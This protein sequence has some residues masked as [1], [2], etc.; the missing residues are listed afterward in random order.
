M[1]DLGLQPWA[2]DFLTKEQ[3]GKEHLYPLHLVYCSSCG[4]VQLDF[5]VPKEVMFSDH[6]YVSGTTKTL[7]NHF[8]ETARYVRNTFFPHATS[9]SV[10]DIGSNDGTQLV[11]YK[12]LGF[13]T[14]GV[15]SCGRVA[16]MAE[17]RGIH[18][19]VD[20]FNEECARK[21]PKKF[22]V[23]NAAGVF[24]HLEELHSATRGIKHVL[25]E[26][27][28]FVIQFLYMKSIVENL[29]FD[30]IYHEHLLYYTLRTVE[31]LLALHGLSPFDGYLAPIHGGSMILFVS[32]AG[33][34]PVS[35]R[36][37]ALYAEEDKAGANSLSWYQKFAQQVQRMKTDTLAYLSAKKKEGKRI[38]GM[39][40]PVK[41]NTFLNFCGIGAQYLDCLVEKNPL[42][43]GLYSPGTHLPIVLEEELTN[44][45]DVYLVL[46]WN[47][48]GEI[49][50]NNAALIARGVEFY[51]PVNPKE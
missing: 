13:D 7:A 19:V 29:A 47:F 38:F 27:G 12:D 35:P 2:N 5:T 48:K 43:K 23:I 14:V 9:P 6:T 18:T 25:C 16:A 4:C 26:D 42:R 22:D 46:A 3:V 30:Q 39:G 49:L 33:R 28:V 31:R 40:A 44:P 50:K 37:S 17:E 45:P 11:Q 21:L 1:L 15:E 41:G 10:L 34:R 36:L 20:F 8:A 24:F 32:H 51:F